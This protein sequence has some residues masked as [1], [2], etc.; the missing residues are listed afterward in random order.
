[1]KTRYC[2][3]C[4]TPITDSVHAWYCPEHRE[5]AKRER[6]ERAEEVKKLKRRLRNDYKYNKNHGIEPTPPKELR[7]TSRAARRWATISWYDLCKELDYFKLKYREAQLMAQ[8]G[9]L[10]EDFGLKHKEVHI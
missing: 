6:I 2:K 3:R 8:Q 7:G 5:I 10:P 4:N 9:T 1:M